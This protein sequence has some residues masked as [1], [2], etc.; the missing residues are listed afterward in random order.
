VPRYDSGL[1]VETQ[2]VHGGQRRPVDQSG[3]ER[4]MAKRANAKMIEVN[5][6]HVAYISHAKETA[7]LIEEVPPPHTSTSSQQVFTVK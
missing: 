1:E 4:T 5:S 2:L 3:Q 6:S 7:R